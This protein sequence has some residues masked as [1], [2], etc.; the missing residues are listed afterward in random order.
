MGHYFLR[1][2]ERNAVL[3][4]LIPADTEDAKNEFEILIK[5]L[6]KYNPEL[7]DKKFGIA[8]SKV[9]LLDDE[10]KVEYIQE[11]KTSFPNIPHFLISSVTQKGLKELKDGL[12]GMIKGRY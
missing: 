6:K 5:E 8:L 3:L 4:F 10:L 7:L 11:L 9:D 12:W 1:H 2:I